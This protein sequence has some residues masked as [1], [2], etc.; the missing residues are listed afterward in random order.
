MRLGNDGW[1]QLFHSPNFFPPIND[2]HYVAICSPSTPIGPIVRS[3][4]FQ[5]AMLAKAVRQLAACRGMYNHAPQLPLFLMVLCSS[6]PGYARKNHICAVMYPRSA[7]S[8][9]SLC[10]NTEN[11]ACRLRPP[12]CGGARAIGG[13]L[14]RNARAAQLFGCLAEVETHTL[15]CF[16]DT[17]VWPLELG[18]RTPTLRCGPL[19]W[20]YGLPRF[21]VAP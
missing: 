12:K 14:K 1:D 13:R 20:G 10:N 5:F 9:K 11:A 16:G 8:H 2:R 4:G 7:V 21:G 3:W 18:I 15:W 19:S 17:L 6:Q